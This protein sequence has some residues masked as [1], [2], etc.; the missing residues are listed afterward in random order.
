MAS[1]KF[2]YISIWSGISMLINDLVTLRG[3][4]CHQGLL[5]QHGLTLITAWISIHMSNKV[6]GEITYSFSNSTGYTV[7]WINNFISYFMMDVITYPCLDYSWYP[8]KYDWYQ[9]L[10]VLLGHWNTVAMVLF[11]YGRH[12][13]IKIEILDVTF[14][15][16]TWLEDG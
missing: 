1:A 14:S 5:Y 8:M 2:Q 13:F 15:T 11:H 9:Y 7:E 3:V 16:E 6:W 12:N 4:F 10:D